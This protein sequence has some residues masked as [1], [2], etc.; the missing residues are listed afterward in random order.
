MQSREK[1]NNKVKMNNWNDNP[2]FFFRVEKTD[3]TGTEVLAWF[4]WLSEALDY[5]HSFIDLSSDFEPYVIEV[6]MDETQ[7]E[8]VPNSIRPEVFDSDPDESDHSLEYKGGG[9]HPDCQCNKCYYGEDAAKW[10]FN[11]SEY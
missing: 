9:H 1:V 8:L 5:A 11:P 10:L 3:A 6:F 2:L 7:Y 4:R